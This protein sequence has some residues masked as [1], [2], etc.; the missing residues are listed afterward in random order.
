MFDVE[1]YDHNDNYIETVCDVEKVTN[2]TH[3]F[4]LKTASGKQTYDNNSY[5]YKIVNE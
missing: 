4:R 1:I 3:C 5:H 2:F